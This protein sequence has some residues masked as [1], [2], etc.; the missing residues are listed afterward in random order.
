MLHACRSGSE[1][2]IHSFSGRSIPAIKLLDQ[3]TPKYIYTVAHSELLG[4]WL[5]QEPPMTSTC[6]FTGQSIVAIN[7]SHGSLSWLVGM[8]AYRCVRTMHA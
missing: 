1:S 8:V 4:Q 5:S 2:F 7:M 6:R 3:Q